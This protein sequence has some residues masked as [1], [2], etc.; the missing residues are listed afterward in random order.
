MGLLIESI[1]I[2]A[3]KANS[4][5]IDGVWIYLVI[6]FIGEY[7][8]FRIVFI[9]LRILK[10]IYKLFPPIVAGK[11]M[12]VKQ[13]SPVGSLFWAYHFVHCYNP[14]FE[15]PPPSAGF[16][17]RRK[18]KVKSGDVAYFSGWIND[19]IFH[20]KFN[21]FVEGLRIKWGGNPFKNCSGSGALPPMDLVEK[22]IKRT[23]ENNGRRGVLGSE[24][25]QPLAP[26]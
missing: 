18:S 2:Q 3:M 17:L 21:F 13:W 19:W 4:I 7:C 12:S 24:R 26:S 10:T 9:P 25:A 6:W 22:K 20:P 8:M 14:P 16:F 11:T 15:W 23:R 1:H 5:E